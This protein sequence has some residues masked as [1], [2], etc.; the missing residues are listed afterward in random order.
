MNDIE[1][2]P[3]VKR[4]V[5]KGAACWVNLHR[6]PKTTEVLCI[7]D[8][9]ENLVITAEEFKEVDEF[10]EVFRAREVNLLMLQIKR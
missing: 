6:T 9:G 4:F 1:N 7:F 2:N 10:D 3:L 8:D 5:E